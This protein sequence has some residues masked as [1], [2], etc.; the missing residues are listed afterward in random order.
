[1]F[2]I[3]VCAIASALLTDDLHKKYAINYS[4]SRG[5]RSNNE[6]I[7]SKQ[8]ATVRG[9]SLQI[10]FL[11]YLPGGIATQMH[12]A[13]TNSVPGEH[14]MIDRCPPSVGCEYWSLWPGTAK[15]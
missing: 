13:W 7:V 5:I 9:M 2:A 11:K 12:L 6:I 3:Y 1:M 10:R 8:P 14:V 4:A 15:K